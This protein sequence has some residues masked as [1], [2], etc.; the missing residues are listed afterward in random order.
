MFIREQRL[1][2]V[3]Q[4]R[5]HI[6]Y[7]DMGDERHGEILTH[8]YCDFCEEFQFNDLAFFDHLNRHHM[9]CHL[10]GDHYKNVY[11]KEYTNLETHFAASHF[12]CPYEICKAK[13]YVAFRTE[14]E[15]KTHLDIE[16]RNDKSGKITANALHGFSNQEENEDDNGGRG[17]GRGRGRGGKEKREDRQKILDNEGID[18]AYYFS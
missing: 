13:C 8:P 9:T 10:C 17:R 1:Y 16:H 12:I 14:D 4:L 2:H 15:L 11:Y 6:E 18:F 5:S 3:K 7:G